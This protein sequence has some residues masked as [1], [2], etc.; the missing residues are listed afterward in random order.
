[1]D[2]VLTGLGLPP[3]GRAYLPHVT[4]ARFGRHGGDPAPFLFA[5]AGL[6]G[7]AVPVTDFTLFESHLGPDG[8]FYEQVARYPLGAA[9]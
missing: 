6:A 9:G 3:E 5:A 4:L 8:A 7:L 2:H 1:M